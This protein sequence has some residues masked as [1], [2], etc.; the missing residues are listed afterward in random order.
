MTKRFLTFC[1]LSS[2]VYHLTAQI[3]PAN[4]S[5][6]IEYQVGYFGEFIARPGFKLGVAYPFYQKLKTK[7][8]Y[9]EAYKQTLTKSKIHQFKIG[10]N[11]AYYHQVNNHNGLLLNVELTY[12]KIKHKSKKPNKLS[13]F[14]VSFGLGYFHYEL[15]GK[16]F[17]PTED[18][19]EEINGNGNALM[20]T[21]ALAWGR[22]LPFIKSI[23][24]RYYVKPTLLFETP[25][26]TGTQVR[27]ALEVGLASSF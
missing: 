24:M 18:G 6:K 10:S 25:A 17:Q 19:F 22:N 15:V 9:S 13:Y 4:F 12:Q 20:P 14:D 8:K 26:G 5:K 1:F 21:F 16:T 7:Q 2:F 27:F 3:D 23:D 11:L